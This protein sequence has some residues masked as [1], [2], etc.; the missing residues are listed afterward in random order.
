MIGSIVAVSWLATSGI[1]SLALGRFR[2]HVIAKYTAPLHSAFLFIAAALL[3]WQTALSLLAINLGVSFV[4]SHAFGQFKED[5]SVDLP[6]LKDQLEALREGPPYNFLFG[7][8]YPKESLAPLAAALHTIDLAQ[9]YLTQR[10]GPDSDVERQR[11]EERA[12]GHYN[13][14]SAIQITDKV[15]Q[16]EEKELMY[17]AEYIS[18]ID[19]ARY[20]LEIK[21]EVLLVRISLGEPLP[22]SDLEK[23][24]EL[25]L[26]QK[27]LSKAPDYPEI[28][29]WV[30]RYNEESS[31]EID[32]LYRA[33]NALWGDYQAR[34]TLFIL[35]RDYGLTPDKDPKTFVPGLESIYKASAGAN[36]HLHALPSSSEGY[37][38]GWRVKKNGAGIAHSIQSEFI[39]PKELLEGRKGPPELKKVKNPSHCPPYS[40][41]I[42]DRLDWL[43][44]L[45]GLQKR[46]IFPQLDWE[47]DFVVVNNIPDLC[48]PF[49]KSRKIEPTTNAHDLARN[50]WRKEL[51]Q[52]LFKDLDPFDD[53]PITHWRLH[54]IH[55]FSEDKV[56]ARAFKTLCNEP[57]QPEC[58]RFAYQEG[59]SL[60]VGTYDYAPIYRGWRSAIQKLVCEVK[61]K[62]TL[63]SEEQA[64]AFIACAFHIEWQDQSSPLRAI[65]SIEKWPVTWWL[66]II[67]RSAAA[68]KVKRSTD[69][70]RSLLELCS[71]K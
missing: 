44:I 53:R 13:R 71:K 32:D 5:S 47:R 38:P 68:A 65:A 6:D 42:Q 51:V 60:P 25:N 39:L 48:N 18:P 27:E 54:L 9:R 58:W 59:R 50:E 55:H 29:A 43:G 26:Y 15:V 34:K 49:F 62:Y 22:T 17:W 66:K 7:R 19:P 1:S 30:S 31:L 10:D 69:S 4:A 40:P 36:T 16:P 12:M 41:I 46:L 21:P 14:L 3:Y 28:A 70:H 20:Q 56:E 33:F 52:A 61:R 24:E 35:M 8:F 23:L 11:L 37:Q 63:S 57:R 67:E 64:L 2:F 45:R